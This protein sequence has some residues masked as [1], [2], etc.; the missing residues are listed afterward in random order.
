MVSVL[1]LHVPSASRYEPPRVS[2]TTLSRRFAVC[3]PG[4]VP[5]QIILSAVA[6]FHDRII[7]A[8]IY[9][10]IDENPLDSVCVWTSS[11][12]FGEFEMS[13]GSFVAW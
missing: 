2:G 10:L 6:K 12:V 7:A 4:W 5:M 8:R 13:Y 3:S 11:L 9:W 1:F